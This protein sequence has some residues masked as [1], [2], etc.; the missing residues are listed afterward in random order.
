[1]ATVNHESLTTLQIEVRD[2]PLL[3]GEQDLSGFTVEVAFVAAGTELEAD[4]V[5]WVAATWHPDSPYARGRKNW[6]VALIQVGPGSTV[7]ELDAGSAYQPYV[8]VTTPTD[9]PVLP[10]ELVIVT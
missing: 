6:Y 5:T 9:V 4:D 7:G 10:A 8:R 1:M 3:D 2:A